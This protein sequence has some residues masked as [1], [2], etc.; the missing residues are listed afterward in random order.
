MPFE[1]IGSP[2]LWGGFLA[3]VLLML[4]LD[5]GLHRRAHEVSVKEAAA[6]SA[7]WIALSAAFGGLIH[8]WFGR[9]RALEFATGYV[10]EKALA[11]DNLFVFLVIFAAFS[12]PT[13][14]QHRVL[15]WAILGALVMRA[16]FILAGGALQQRFHWLLYICSRW[17]SRWCCSSSARR[18]SSPA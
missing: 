9:E 6:W 5:L 16:A 2:A 8:H 3:F 13:A 15:F 7:V 17:A 4:A 18:W 10:I 1:T 14:L 11:V 12:V